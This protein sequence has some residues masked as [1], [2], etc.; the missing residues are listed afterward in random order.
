MEME[1]FM[2]DSGVRIRLMAMENTFIQMEQCTRGTG[3]R[4]SSMGRGRRCGWTT[5]PPMMDTTSWGRRMGWA[6][7]SGVMGLTTKGSS[8]IMT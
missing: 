6:S 4:T 2:R 5:D 7:S 3:R 8:L 1:T